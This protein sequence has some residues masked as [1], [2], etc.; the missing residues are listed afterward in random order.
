MELALTMGP[1]GDGFEGRSALELSMALTTRLT[2]A[3]DQEREAKR[4]DDEIRRQREEVKAAAAK[5]RRGARPADAA[6]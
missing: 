4:L 5:N 1:D 6:P 2:T 3:R